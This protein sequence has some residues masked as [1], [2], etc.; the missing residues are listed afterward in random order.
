MCVIIGCFDG[1]WKNKG[2]YGMWCVGYVGWNC[3]WNGVLGDVENVE[4]NL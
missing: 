3:N 2:M 1:G 4:C